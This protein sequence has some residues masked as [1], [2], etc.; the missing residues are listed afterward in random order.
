MIDSIKNK[1]V[2]I[3]GAALG[4]G[5]ATALLL[6]KHGARVMVI[7]LNIDEGEQ[8]VQMINKSGGHGVFYQ[9]DVSK[10]EQVALIF[11]QIFE[12]EGR[13]DFAVNNAG[14][15]GGIGAIHEIPFSAWDRMIGVCLS[16]V[17]YCMKEEIKYMLSNKFGRIVNV[18][19]L[20]GLNGIGTGADYSAAKHGVIGLTK[21][22]ALEYGEFNIRTNAVCP[23]FIQTAILDEVP[24]EVQDYST[25]IR[26]PLKRVGKPEEV[27]D[28]VLWLLS[29]ASSYVNGDQILIDGGFKAG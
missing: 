1:V 7:D 18:S 25:N 4:I 24:Q 21:T 29:D 11:K 2:V 12:I 13:I 23:G 10:R 9:L 17:F 5:R 20:A 22:A 15:G 14:I 26:V 6:A 8:T 27:A 19:S 16:G 28:V 3:T